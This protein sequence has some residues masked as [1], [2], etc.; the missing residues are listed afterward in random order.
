MPADK[1]PDGF[2]IA[3]GHPDF[4]YYSTSVGPR[5]GNLRSHMPG[6]IYDPTP[7]PRGTVRP[8]TPEGTENPAAPGYAQLLSLIAPSA[9]NPLSGSRS[10]PARSY[11]TT[12][13]NGMP[14]VV[15]VTQPDHPLYPGVVMRYETT[16]PSGSTIH[17]EGSGLAVVQGP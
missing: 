13:Q 3:P 16:S 17:N 15:N 11:Q 1:L 4:H 6:V 5:P 9:L 7:G 8:A 12:D 10:W 14:V 2:G